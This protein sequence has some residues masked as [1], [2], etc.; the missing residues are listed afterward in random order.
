L[1]NAKPLPYASSLCGACKQACPVDIDLPRMLLD[2]RRD[3]VNRGATERKWNIGIK[4]WARV[5]ASP[6]LFALGGKFA[7]MGMKTKIDR[8]AP[9]PLSDWR[10]HRDFPD[11][12]P[13]PFRQLWQER[14]K[15]QHDD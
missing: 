10:K 13:K 6:R 2:L 5:S 1:D 12:A 4:V 7:R 8:V 11:F 9:N 14:Q 3:M 15:D